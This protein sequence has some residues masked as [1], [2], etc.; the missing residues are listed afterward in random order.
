VSNLRAWAEA[1]APSVDPAWDAAHP[2]EFTVTK[3][4]WAFPLLNLWPTLR[5]DPALAASDRETIDNWILNYLIAPIP[6]PDFWPND[7]GYWSDASEMAD[8]IRRSDNATFA[9]V[10]QRFY[11]ALKQMR[12]DGSFPL[13]AG[14][15]ACSATYSN[16]DLTHL[17][18]MAEMAATQGYDL[19]SMN[20]NGKSL[21]TAIEFMLN[22][23]ENPA[24]PAWGPV[25]K[26]IPATR[27]IS[28]F[29]NIRAPLWRGWSRILR[30]FRYPPRRRVCGPSWAVT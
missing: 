14:L 23:Y 1:N 13:A 11:G 16:T 27:Q 25:L 18:S 24:L 12:A 8:A 9:F 6:V 17:T 29:T 19:Y 15:S 20:V 21:E 10:V 22:A 2:G 30:A 3:S 26:E 7:L 28:P 4:Q 5:A